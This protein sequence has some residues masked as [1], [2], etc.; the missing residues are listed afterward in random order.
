MKEKIKIGQ[1]GVC[2][3]HAGI[4][5]S[6]RRLPEVFE[7]AGVVDD[8]E[9]S[10]KAKFVGDDF[11]AFE[12]LP[13]VS[14][15]ELFQIPGLQAVMVERPNLELVETALRC[16]RRNVAIHMDKPGGTSLAE[17]RELLDECRT[18]RLPF[19]MGYM[20][21]GNPAMQWCLKAAKAGYFGEIFEVQASMSHRYG[22]EAYQDYLGKLPGGILFNLGSHLV[23]FVAA[24]LGRPTGVTPFLKAAPGYP[25]T[26]LNC[27]MAV[28]EY[29]HATATLRACSQECDGLERR[30]LKICGTNASVELCPLECFD[31]RRLQMRLALETAIPGYEAGIHTLDF[32]VISDRFA[33]HLE[34]FA[35]MIRGEIENPYSYEHDLL[36]EEILLAASGLA[37]WR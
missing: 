16:A 9:F 7:I 8:R 13:F 24:L 30:R 21:R 32:G 12:G 17:F 22:G 18:R 5:K 29:P 34:E 4:M 15:E 27:G 26:I 6:L 10:S 35:G 11:S 28:L 31:G 2:H 14:E 19:Q 36:T 33:A 1:I 3:E 37:T 23:D 25:E 20:F